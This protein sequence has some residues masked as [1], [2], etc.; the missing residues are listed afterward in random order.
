MQRS[1]HLLADSI[2]VNWSGG[3]LRPNLALYSVA[4]MVLPLKIPVTNTDAVKV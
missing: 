3:Y 4:V 1:A 2:R